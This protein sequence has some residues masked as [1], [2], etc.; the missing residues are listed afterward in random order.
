[1]T[2]QFPYTYTVLR[3][4]HDITTGEF[5]NV[6]VLLFSPKA[7]YVSALCRT[8]LGR[9]S[10]V[11]P[12]LNGEQFK[13]VMRHIQNK[14]EELNDEIHSELPFESCNTALDIARRIL[15]SDDSALQWSSIGSGR[16]S[17]PSATLEKLFGRMVMQYDQKTAKQHRSDDDIWRQ[18][19]RDLESRSLLQ[20]FQPKKISVK[21]DEIEFRHAW[22][23][24]QW[25]CIEPLSFD[26]SSADSI[27]DKAHRWLGQITSISNSQEKFRLYMLVGK[28]QDPSL[29]SAFESALSILKKM[30]AENEIFSIEQ[31]TQLT[32]TLANEVATHQQC[33]EDVKG[34][35]A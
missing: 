17:D 14:A 26:L 24:G 9:L 27:R 16:S 18:F 28:P 2:I 6:G 29:N 21:D 4:V 12:G 1:M 8:T 19:K 30:P 7:R 32:E 34:Q 23:N 11:F 13:S 3:Y 10:H 22:K 33:L 25:H 20:Y 31:I 15:P 35:Q 5:V